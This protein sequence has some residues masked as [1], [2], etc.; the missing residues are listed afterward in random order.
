MFEVK[1]LLAQ[2]QAG[3]NPDELADMFAQSLN[4]AMDLDKKQKEAEAAAKAKEEAAAQ[5]ETEL[6]KYAEEMATAMLNYIKIASPEAAALLAEEDDEAIDVAD[7]RKMLDASVKTILMTMKFA[8]A[9]GADI[10]TPVKSTP[11]PKATKSAD[12]AI[13]Q[14]LNAFGL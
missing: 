5:K 7:V 10:P 1:D 8:S 9:F 6:N 13:S 11:D 14:F 4:A 2:I 12:D 3:A